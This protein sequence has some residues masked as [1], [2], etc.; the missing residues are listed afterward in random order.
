MRRE[1]LENSDE[2][3]VV[4]RGRGGL[5]HDIR[6]EVEPVES[7]STL[8]TMPYLQGVSVAGGEGKKGTLRSPNTPRRHLL[9][10]DKKHSTATHASW[11]T[12]VA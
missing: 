3:T 2:T 10:L 4:R 7:A 11:L 12:L 6:H 1:G 5:Q 9:G 8:L